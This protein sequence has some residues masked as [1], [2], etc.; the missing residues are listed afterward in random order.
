MK[1]LL[2]SWYWIIFLL[3]VQTAIGEEKAV[4]TLP[5]EWPR[6]GHDAAL[7]GRSAC[8]GDIRSPNVA[9]S[10]SLT[11]WNRIV[12]LIPTPGNHRLKI[13]ADFD[14][15]PSEPPQI[16]FPVRQEMDVDGSGTLRPVKETSH[17]RWAKIIPG[18]PGLQRV[19]WS[20]TWTTEKVCRLQLFAFDRGYDQPRLVWQTDPPEGTIFS[21]LNLVYDIDHDGVQEI[22]T[23]AHYRVMIFEGTTGRKE[24]ELTYHTCRPYGWFGIADVDLDNHPEL[25]TLGDFQS[26]FDVLDYDS[27]K[28]EAQRLSVRWRRDVETHIE[29]RSKWPQI[30]PHPLGNVSGD[31]RLELILNLFNDHND[32]Q[33]HA[34]V[35]DASSG[36]ALF[37]FPQRYVQG[38]AD[39]DRDGYDELFLTHT[40]GIFVPTYGRVE[41]LNLSGN[42]AVTIWSQE[43]AGWATSDL[44]E[45]DSNWSTSATQGM[46]EIIIAKSDS[47]LPVFLTRSV[48]SD[49]PLSS[50]ELKMTLSA[51]RWNVAGK[52]EELW[53]VIDLPRGAEP[54]KTDY[55]EGTNR[56]G[57]RLH[58]PMAAHTECEPIGKD[59]RLV[60][61]ESHKINTPLSPPIAARLQ[62]GGP[63]VIVVESAGNQVVAMVPT[64]S[65]SAPK[66]LWQQTGRGMGDGS[67]Q[68]GML[69]VDLNQDGGKEIVLADQ[70]ISGTAR[71]VAIRNDGS[72]LWEH[73]FP[74]IPGDSPRW[75]VGALTFW[76]PGRFRDP[77]RFDLFVN[78]RRGLMHS[79][80][81]MVLDGQTGEVVWSQ[82][83]AIVDNIFKWGYAGIPLAV[84]DVNQD[85]LDEL[86]DLYPV[87]FWIADGKDGKIQVAQDLA[88]QKLLPAWAAYGEPMV[89]DF[90]QDGNR[91]IL[92]DS[93][94]ILA[95][96][97]TK[98]DVIWHGLGRA[99]YPTSPNE[100]NVGETTEVKHALV[101]FNGDG[102]FELA[103]G[104]YRDGI[105]AIDS[106][107]GKV[108][109][110]LEAPTPTC[111]KMCAADIDGQPG[112]ELIYP[113]GDTLVCVNSDLKSGKITWTWNAPAKLSAPAIADVDGDKYAEIIVKSSD[114]TVW[115]LDG[116]N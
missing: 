19:A 69:A 88:A 66:L 87:C 79:D 25:I 41:L 76:W 39:V 26:H 105:R 8:Q 63:V 104:G 113:S 52:M 82:Q 46:Q 71:L 30:P 73:S 77:H 112:D 95:M 90:N 115:C 58:V 28:P 42:Q 53:R 55:L 27:E 96:L 16:P 60:P 65:H 61:I 13:N 80:E 67:R 48:E 23:A 92:L 18:I 45:M 111:Q 86:I 54:L 10:I 44:P 31:R 99:D 43:R 32:N 6:Y 114:G 11:G 57:V 75:N 74:Q 56:A 101:D 20:H 72:V 59:V 1:R 15:S 34:I 4:I 2:L 36:I 83:K 49:M 7:T 3:G 40:D 17:E 38:H 91:E 100:G 51:W 78:I 12:E 22:C 89:Y 94:Y 50:N 102:R 116:N 24:S 14:S 85:N 103:S 81:G 108:I 98:G 5:D 33:W 64:A 93:V 106:I 37:D 21:P 70:T 47:Q 29:E 62:S 107:T 9:W 97:N 35:L 68:C 84:D 110:T 109:W